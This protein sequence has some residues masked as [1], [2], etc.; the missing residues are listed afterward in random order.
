M[1]YLVFGLCLR[2]LHFLVL[3][4]RA[5]RERGCLLLWLGQAEGVGAYG[6]I[7]VRS[8]PLCSGFAS[9]FCWVDWY[10][11]GMFLCHCFMSVLGLIG[12]VCLG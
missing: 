1:A 12:L 8:E 3:Y 11:E 10:F 6:L 7:T 5:H 2:C 9:W 4:F